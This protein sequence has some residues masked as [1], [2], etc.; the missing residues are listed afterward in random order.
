[1]AAS[2]GGDV[3][4]P[5]ED[6]AA[7]PLPDDPAERV[8]AIVER[9]VEALDLPA[10]GVELEEDDEEIRISVA[11]EDLGLLIGR[12]GETIDSLQH[13]VARAAFRDAEDRKRVVVDA[14]GYR[15]RREAALRKAADRA[16]DDALSSGRSVELEPMSSF[17]RRIVHQYL[18]DRTDVETYSEGVEPERRLVVEPV[19]ADQPG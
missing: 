12:H 13:I 3:V 8:R 16:V 9:G 14:A 11:G 7:E 5:A 15:G 4:E 18:K 19:R 1:M 17:E 10:E 2:E 6:A